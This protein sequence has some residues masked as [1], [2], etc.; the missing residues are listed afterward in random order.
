MCRSSAKGGRKCPTHSDPQWI[1]ERNARR[2]AAYAQKVHPV[3]AFENPHQPEGEKRIIHTPLDE[4]WKKFADDSRAFESKVTDELLRKELQDYTGAH[5]VP[6][7]DYLN[8]V[9]LETNEPL[10]LTPEEEADLKSRVT[11]L[12]EA[13]SLAEKPS[14]PRKLYRG[15][16]VNESHGDIEDWISKNYPVGETVEQKSYMS[17]SMNPHQAVY[18]G[19]T[20]TG[21]QPEREIVFEFLTKEGAPLGDET[22]MLGLREQEVILPRN[23]KFKVAAVHRNSDF[24]YGNNE[25]DSLNRTFRKTVIQLIDVD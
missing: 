11:R 4:E 18:F 5:F 24:T 22:S 1:A 20:T 6:I 8:G 17:S 7:R 15:I 19:E 14:Q 12:D 16:S 25:G 21:T 23:S 13:I 2:R 3:T 10:N 9:N